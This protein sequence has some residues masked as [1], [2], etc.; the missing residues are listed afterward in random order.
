MFNFNNEINDSAVKELSH[1]LE[2]CRTNISLQQMHLSGAGVTYLLE[3]KLCNYYKKKFALCFSNGTTALHA[4]CL[5]MDLK[6]SEI[7]SSPINWGGS[8]APF[9]LHKNK[10]RFTSFNELSL[11]LSINDL[12]N[13][14]TSNTKAVLSVD[15]NGTPVDSHKIKNVCENH[16]LFYISDSAQSFGAYFMNKP[17]GFFA[18]VIV[19]SFSAGKSVFAGEGG[20]IL[21]DREDLYEKLLWY[22]QHPLKQKSILGL[23][24]FNEYSPLN[25]RMNPLSAILLNETFEQNLEKLKVSQKQHFYLVKKLTEEGF[26]EKP[27]QISS[28]YA[29]TYFNLIFRLKRSSNLQKLNQ[30]FQKAK[31][32]FEAAPAI[33]KLIPFE[34]IFQKQFKDNFN[35]TERLKLQYKAFN[36]LTSIKLERVDIVH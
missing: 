23:S 12:V 21:T 19:L 34:K 33:I 2:E 36:P 26:I 25:G 14:I 22:S 20:A 13:A 28:F 17:A 9:L 1:Y 4:I 24:S 7:I 15:F 6:N 3:R 11:N 32:P 31:L 16:G 18:D 30:F 10:I 35:C 27:K 5:A 8:I 29:S